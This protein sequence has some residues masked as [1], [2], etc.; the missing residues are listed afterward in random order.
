MQL[1]ARLVIET[2]TRQNIFIVTENG[3][4]PFVQIDGCPKAAACNL[5]SSVTGYHIEPNENNWLT[6]ELSDTEYDE[7]AQVVYIIYV[8]RVPEKIEL[9]A[10]YCWLD[11]H[12]I[13]D[14]IERIRGLL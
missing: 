11:Y 12:S 14:K 13:R 2:H 9:K 3:E 5:L 1:N 4:L 7:K 10:P 6:L 8:V